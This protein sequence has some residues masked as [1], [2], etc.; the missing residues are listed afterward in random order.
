MVLVQK[1]PFFQLFFQAIQEKKMSLTIFQS[2]EM[3]FQAIKTKSTKSRKIDILP[4]GLTHD[5]GFKMA[6]SP[7]FLF[8]QYRP[9]KSLFF[10]FKTSSL[11]SLESLFFVLEYRKRHFPG[12]YCLKKMFKK[13][14]IFGPRPWVNLFGKMSIFR[15]LD[16]FFLQ[17][18]KAFFFFFLS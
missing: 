3:P 18:R 10:H 16:F 15:L 9:G 17:P 1:W 6:I 14:A 4:K 8:R 2:E 7:S 11:Y 13:M 5:F 12:L